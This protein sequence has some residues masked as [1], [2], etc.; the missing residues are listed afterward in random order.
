MIYGYPWSL[1][2]FWSF[3]LRFSMIFDMIGSGMM[4]MHRKSLPFWRLSLMSMEIPKKIGMIWGC[5]WVSPIE[6][7]ISKHNWDAFRAIPHI[8]F[9]KNAGKTTTQ[10]KTPASELGCPGARPRPVASGWWCWESKGY[11]KVTAEP[12]RCYSP[13]LDPR[14]CNTR[15]LAGWLARKLWRGWASG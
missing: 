6:T 13:V 4:T 10:K 9:P 15:N 2:H 14:T 8:F 11:T 12:T 3:R 5:P 7:T 1:G